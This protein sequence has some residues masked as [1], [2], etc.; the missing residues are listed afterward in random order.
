[1]VST[2]TTSRTKTAM[3]T[4]RAAATVRRLSLASRA[5]LCGV[6][7]LAVAGCTNPR[8]GRL[9]PARSAILGAGVGGAL[10]ALPGLLNEGSGHRRPYG[11]G[12]GFGR[13]YGGGAYLPPIAGPLGGGYGYGRGW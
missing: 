8:T 6:A 1:M 12:G 5:A 2:D 10:F 7:A 4:T 13:G 9:D 11:H 3:G